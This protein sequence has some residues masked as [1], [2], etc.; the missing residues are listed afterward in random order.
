MN[1]KFAYFMRPFFGQKL[2]IAVSGGVDSMALLHMTVELGLD[3]V[4]VHVNH[5]LRGAAADNDANV[6]RGA[7]RRLGVGC[8]VLHWT[9]DKPTRGV[10]A[11]ARTARY[12]LMT[13]FCR[14]RGIGTLMVAHQADDQIETFLMN[15]ARGSG[16][17][18]LA[19]MQPMSMR[20][21]VMIVRPLLDVPRA[22][23][24]K[25]CNDRG[26]ECVHD[27]MNDDTRFAR[28]R[29]RMGRHVLRDM[30]GISDERILLATQNLGRS[31]AAMESYVNDRIRTVMDGRAAYMPESFLFDEPDDIRL[32]LLGNLL[33]RVGGGNYQP[34]LNSLERALHKLG[35]D[36]QFTLGRCTVRK[37]RNHILIV[38]EGSSTSFRKRNEK[39]KRQ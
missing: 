27:E 15:L 30:L 9:G 34:R 37:F 24:E 21:G 23:L 38:A 3:V 35:S 12:K 22:Q 6:V 25:Y 1:Q 36:C 17:Y 11:A 16:L 28:V 8:H 19:G 20:D 13:D 29:M 33:Q 26:I 18:G 4:A 39:T 10:E 32:K 2:A 14:A 5:G 7:C 31:R